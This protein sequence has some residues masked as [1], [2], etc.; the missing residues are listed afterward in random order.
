MQDMIDEVYQDQ[1]RWQRMS[2]LNTA[3]C[4]FFSSD[5]SILDYNDRIWHC[6]PCAVPSPTD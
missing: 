6:A 4:G 5:R 1:E 2:V 3:G